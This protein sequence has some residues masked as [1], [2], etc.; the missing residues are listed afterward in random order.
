MSILLLPDVKNQGPQTGRMTLWLPPTTG[1]RIGSQ[2]SSSHVMHRIETERLG[3][4]SE[5]TLGG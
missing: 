1:G 3:V 5:V 4:V 2:G